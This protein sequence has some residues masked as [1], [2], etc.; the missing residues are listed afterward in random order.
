V[1]NVNAGA[2]L[3]QELCGQLNRPLNAV[4]VLLLD[5]RAFRIRWNPMESDGI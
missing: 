5:L 2:N 1:H 4:A 3:D